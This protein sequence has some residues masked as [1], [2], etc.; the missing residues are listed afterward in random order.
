LVVVVLFLSIG[1][2]ARLKY[3]VKGLNSAVFGVVEPS[4]WTLVD[5]VHV[6]SLSEHGVDLVFRVDVINEFCVQLRQ[7]LVGV[8]WRGLKLVDQLDVL[9]IILI[10]GDI[11]VLSRG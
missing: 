9:L 11:E 4:S 6:V 10:P 8:G 7:E 5:F 2:K 3:V 1:S